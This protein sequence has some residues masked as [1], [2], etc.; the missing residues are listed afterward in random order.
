ML[1]IQYDILCSFQFEH[2]FYLGSICRE[3][4]I[5][6]TAESVQQMD[7]YG[8]L[9]KRTP[10]Q[11]CIVQR[12]EGGVAE[13]PFD[14]PVRLCFWVH[15]E[16]P[17]LFRV[18]DTGTATQFYLTN[19]VGDGTLRTRLTQQTMLSE[20]DQAPK[21]VGKRLNLNFPKGEF[22][23]LSVEQFT[24]AG[25]VQTDNVAIDPEAE[26]QQITFK[27]SGKY[28]LT[29]APMP[30]GQSPQIVFSDGEV[31]GNRPFWAVIDLHLEA[32]VALRTQYRVR[33]T[34]KQWKWQYVL[35]DVKSKTVDFGP[36]DGREIEVKHEAATGTILNFS[37]KTLAELPAPQAL[38]LT[39]IKQIHS[40]ILNDLFVF[41]SAELLPIFQNRPPPVIKFEANGKTIILP[42]PTLDTL[43]T[44]ENKAVVFF[45][46]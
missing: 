5:I 37:K 14:A 2:D 9:F 7:Q 22:Q 31:A 19:M 46:I 11:T 10:T 41:E 44:F 26:V 20:Q 30:A 29:K 27:E 15:F 21:M 12:I 17:A 6:P 32:S 16:N 18:C 24:K 3:I 28:R 43:Q 8:L 38:Q 35:M 40:D 45:N 39:Q 1:N 4:K 36:T 42:V 13:T 25:W 34:N 33:I 23:Q